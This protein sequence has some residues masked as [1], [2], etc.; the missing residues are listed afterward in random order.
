MRPIVLCLTLLV[1]PVA[2]FNLCFAQF[3]AGGSNTI[4]NDSRKIAIHFGPDAF[5]PNPVTGQPYSADRIN[6][7]VQTLADGT[8]INQHSTT[9]K[10]FRDSLGRQRVERA[11][12]A[13]PR[14]NEPG[15]AVVEIT[16]PTAGYRYVLDDTN[17]VVHRLQLQLP[18]ISSGA[19]RSG[20]VP[21][22]VI[23]GMVGAA[24]ATD[25]PGRRDGDRPAFSNEDLGTQTIEGIVARGR[26]TTM[27]YPVGSQGND[28]PIVVTNEFWS[29]EDLR[30][31]ILSKHNDP[32][33]GESTMK[34]TNISRTEPDPALFQLPGDYKV[35]DETGPFTI[36]VARPAR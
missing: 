31:L 32:R 5:A 24:P 1:V 22:G 4:D 20:T 23:G 21:T 6:E 16:D 18:K 33:N 8:H 34:L 36:E 15:I 14:L 2:G 9:E 25:P 13:M 35:V 7:R 26:R 11:M 27:T 3:A 28:R 17:K 12:M 10:V 30:V 29:A 19:P